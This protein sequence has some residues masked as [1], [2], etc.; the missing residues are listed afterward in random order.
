[1]GLGSG[2]IFV[3][4]PPGGVLDTTI[5]WRET[6]EDD[7]VQLTLDSIHFSPALSTAV[8]LAPPSEWPS[9]VTGAEP[10]LAPAPT[11]T[12]Q[13]LGTPTP[14]AA[15]FPAAVDAPVLTAGF[16]IDG[17][18]WQ[19]LRSRRPDATPDGIRYRWTFD[20]VSANA[21][22]LQ[23]AVMSVAQAGS[24]DA[25]LWEWTVPLREQD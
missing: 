16:S 24:E 20:P 8:V 12:P 15:P 2:I 4:T 7:G 21:E 10:V 6:R 19:E 25:L 3:V 11:R 22:T 14:M 5:T 9:G 13:S 17:G 23:F 18:P 1:M